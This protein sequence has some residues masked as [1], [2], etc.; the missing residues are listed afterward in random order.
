MRL[1]RS[2]NLDSSILPPD[3]TVPSHRLSLLLF[4]VRRERKPGL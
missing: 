4:V 3:G 1:S 2:P